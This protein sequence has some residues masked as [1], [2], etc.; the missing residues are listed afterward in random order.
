M[1]RVGAFRLSLA[2]LANKLKS[3]LHIWVH[4]N[5]NIIVNEYLKWFINGKVG[6]WERVFVRNDLKS[7]V[8][9]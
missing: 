1:Y 4:K 6:L 7:C 9:H 5:S 8:Q 2:W 3:F